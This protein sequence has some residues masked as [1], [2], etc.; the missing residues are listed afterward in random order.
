MEKQPRRKFKRTERRNFRPFQV[1]YNNHRCISS[2]TKEELIENI[3]DVQWVNYEGKRLDIEVFK[4][5]LEASH[6]LLKPIFPK[7]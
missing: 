5:K 6:P 4:K 3:N 2:M 7:P 1:C